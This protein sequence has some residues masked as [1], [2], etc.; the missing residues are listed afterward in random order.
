MDRLFA[1]CLL[2][3]LEVCSASSN[4]IDEHRKLSLSRLSI[5]TVMNSPS[6]EKVVIVSA[7]AKESRPAA[8]RWTLQYDGSRVSP[9][10]FNISSRAAAA[11]KTIACTDANNKTHC[12]VYGTNKNTIP[13][14]DIVEAR[15]RLRTAAQGS[16]T[17]FTLS[18]LAGA[19]S[20]GDP[21]TAIA[22]PPD[23]KSEF[24]KT[25]APR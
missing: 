25:L 21:L 9:I 13:D 15:F 2:L 18:H 22:S 17:R 7:S 11:R 23:V 10:S 1:S 8:L 3:T 19:S 16:D 12:I 14:G 24:P 20:E 5:S 6:E 4:R